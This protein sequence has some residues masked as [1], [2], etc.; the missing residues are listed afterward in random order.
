[1]IFL[2]VCIFCKLF[3]KKTLVS[4][5]AVYFCNYSERNVYFQGEGVGDLTESQFQVKIR[6]ICFGDTQ[7]HHLG[8]TN[9]SLKFH[10][11][12]IRVW[13][14]IIVEAARCEQYTKKVNVLECCFASCV[15]IVEGGSKSVPE[16]NFYCRA[17][18]RKQ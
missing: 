7:K 14:N 2:M 1:M 12:R 17:R 13:K 18:F 3:C 11:K 5:D 10:L 15:Y 4:F 16:L 8:F 6:E 9:G